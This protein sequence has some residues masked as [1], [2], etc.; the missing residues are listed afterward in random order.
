MVVTP[1]LLLAAV[2]GSPFEPEAEVV[3]GLAYG[4]TNFSESAALLVNPAGARGVSRFLI[5]G[6]TTGP[7]HW[8]KKVLKPAYHPDAPTVWWGIRHD[9]LDVLRYDKS[10]PRGGAIRVVDMIGAQGV[11]YRRP[12]PHNLVGEI[13]AKESILSAITTLT[14]HPTA[15][16]SDISWFIESSNLP[17]GRRL[18]RGRVDLDV[19]LGPPVP[20][21]EG[22][23][24][25]SPFDW[26][27]NFL[28][29]S[30]GR[31]VYLQYILADSTE[32]RASYGGA[33]APG[34]PGGKRILRF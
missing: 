12:V 16:A 14:Q 2:A 3:K 18:W 5:D 31:S 23:A 28:F 1:I 26:H 19:E 29:F 17:S 24:I 34:G 21:K 22:R 32:P 6:A 8:A 4:D 13:E 20:G 15:P 9:L 30:D 10:L 33:V 11:F 7:Q 25:L 27:R